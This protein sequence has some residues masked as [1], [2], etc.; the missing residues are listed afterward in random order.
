MVKSEGRGTH[1]QVK[2]LFEALPNPKRLGQGRILMC[3]RGWSTSAGSVRARPVAIKAGAKTS[4]CLMQDRNYPSPRKH[5]GSRRQPQPQPGT[6]WAEQ[7][8]RIPMLRRMLRLKTRPGLQPNSL[9]QPGV[10]FRGRSVER[11]EEILYCTDSGRC[12]GAAVLAMVLL[13][14][15][16][17]ASALAHNRLVKLMSSS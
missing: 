7:G 4:P 8:R 17:P 9:S 6:W 10:I 15:R 5:S 12:S 14:S 16:A 13:V 2:A 3:L 11:G 1:L